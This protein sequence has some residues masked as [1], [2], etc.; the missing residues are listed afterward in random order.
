MTSPDEPAARTPVAPRSSWVNAA[1]LVDA[2]D[3]SEIVLVRHGQQDIVPGGPHRDT[4]DPPLSAIGRAQ[5]AAVGVRFSTETF[6]ALYASPYRRALETG[7]AIGAHHGIEPIVRDDLREVEIFRSL[8]AGQTLLDRYGE[9]YMLG[10]RT[11]MIRER[12]WDVYPDSERSFDFRQRVVNQ[13]EAI[14]HAHPAQR[15]V[16][17]C[18][19][20]VINAYLAHVVG[21]DADMWFHPR[22]TAVNVVWAAAGGRSLRSIN[23]ATHL[24]DDLLTS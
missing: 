13:I 20:G 8:P 12:R 22:H 18:H 3:R 19:A 4:I 14:I 23:D 17:A 11:R 16:I 24:T 2:T 21:T 6:D 1:F 10:L 7:R 15:V 5:A 9:D